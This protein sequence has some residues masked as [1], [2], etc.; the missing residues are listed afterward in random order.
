M[1]GMEVIARILIIGGDE[2]LLAHAKG[3]DDTFLPGGHV[4]IGEFAEQAGPP[5]SRPVA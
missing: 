1:R 2:M 4:E 5:P 3:E